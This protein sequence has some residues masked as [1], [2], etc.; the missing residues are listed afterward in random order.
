MF[1]IGFLEMIVI[2][3]ISLLVLGPERLPGAARAAGKWIGKAKR[4]V[5]QFSSEID[6]QLEI[7]ELRAQ[8]K[9][10]GEHLNI[11]DDIQSIQKTAKTIL[12]DVKSAKP[13]DFIKKAT[14]PISR[15]KKAIN[16]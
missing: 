11:N 2:G 13:T 8:L 14:Q 12:K 1:D 9:E 4:M 6:K 3:I 5:S 7:D 15:L 10:Q 16:E